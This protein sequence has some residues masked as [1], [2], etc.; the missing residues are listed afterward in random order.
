MPKFNFNRRVPSCHVNKELLSEIESYIKVGLEKKIGMTQ[1]DEIRYK[2]SIEDNIG[3]ET[4]ESIKEYVPPMF[5][6]GTKSIRVSWNNGYK[7]ESRLE[8]AIYFD[9]EYYVSKVEVDSDARNA[10]EMAVGTGDGILRIL[11]SHRTFNWIFNPFSLPFL[12]PIIFFGMA[13]CISAGAARIVSQQK[14]LYFLAFAALAGW[15]LLSSKYFRP[16]ISFDSRRQLFLGKLWSY[17]SIGTIG[18]IIFGSL[19]PTIRKIFFGF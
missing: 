5:P 11:D 2:V 19:F 3:I 4:L 12:N 6:D 16:F 15:Y 8:I 10:K 18:F 13:F 17:F 14:G 7:T 1:D 9:K